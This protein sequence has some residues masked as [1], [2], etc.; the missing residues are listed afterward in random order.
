MSERRVELTSSAWLFNP[1]RLFWIAGQ[2]NKNRPF[3][4]QIGVEL[5]P[6]HYF[7]GAP[8]GPGR[9]SKEKI[10]TWQKEHGP[11]PVERIHL[12]FHYN[13]PSAF[14]RRSFN[15]VGYEIKVRKLKKLID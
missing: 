2:I 13:F 15:E 9:I 8:M 7:M 5:Y 10:R 3:D 11:V 14:V 1:E 6:V 4:A 12:S